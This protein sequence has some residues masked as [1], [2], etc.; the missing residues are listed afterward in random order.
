MVATVMFGA[1][2]TIEPLS[3]IGVSSS[4]RIDR[5]RWP[6]SSTTL[7][8][9]LR[10]LICPNRPS[11]DDGNPGGGE[12]RDTAFSITAILATLLSAL[13]LY[14]LT[15]HAASQRTREIGV[16]MA[17][18]ATRGRI[19]WLFLREVMVRVSVSLVLGLAGALGAGL[20]L[21]GLLVDVR[22]NDPWL[23]AA[24]GGFLAAVVIGAGLLPALRAARLD[25]A[26]T[27]RAD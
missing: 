27:L 4:N 8:S 25:P 6:G 9:T 1:P 26:A 17:L 7:Y 20:A 2:D 14:S 23:L 3:T 18:G 11:P 5:T 19:S 10:P 12:T 21:Q 16:R 22:A 15:A 13:G 24:V